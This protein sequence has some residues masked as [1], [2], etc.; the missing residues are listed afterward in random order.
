MVLAS[1][2]DVDSGGFGLGACGVQT[3]ADFLLNLRTEREERFEECLV[4]LWDDGTDGGGGGGATAAGGDDETE[5]GGGEE[6]DEEDGVRV[7]PGG[8]AVLLLPPLLSGISRS[9]LRTR[10]TCFTL[11]ARLNFMVDYF[12]YAH[13]HGGSSNNNTHA[14]IPRIPPRERVYQC[15]TGYSACSRVDKDERRLEA[16]YLLADEE[17]KKLDL[18]QKWLT[19]DDRLFLKRE[20][21]REYVQSAPRRGLDLVLWVTPVATLVFGA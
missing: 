19:V 11:A 13:T 16:R 7:A 21:E 8:G 1:R 2:V 14:K 18:K 9:G 15:I 12:A 3:G 10:V 20:R 6:E 4:P 17:E 5:D